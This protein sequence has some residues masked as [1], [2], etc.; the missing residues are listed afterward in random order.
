MMDRVVS[1]WEAVVAYVDD[2]WVGSPDKQTHLVHLEALFATLAANGQAINL[3]NCVFTILT[4]EIL[5][6]AISAAGSNPMA[7][8]IA[9]IN[10][11]PALRTSNNHN[12]FSA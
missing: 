12:V 1:R 2:S 5:G 7:G 10:T 3:E 6:H 8:H 11:S 9:A 4:L